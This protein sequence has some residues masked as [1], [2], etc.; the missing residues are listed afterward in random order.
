MYLLI[1]VNTYFTRY[2]IR[3]ILKMDNNTPHWHLLVNHHLDDFDAIHDLIHGWDLDFHQLKPGNSPV[4]ICQFGNPEFVITK[5]DVRQAYDQRGAAADNAI[6]LAVLEDGIEEVLCPRG[7]FD[8]SGMMYFPPGSDINAVSRSR[9]KGYTLT[10]SQALIDEVCYQQGLANPFDNN[11]REQKPVHCGLNRMAV[12]RQGLRAVGRS[13]LSR[14]QG[15]EQ[16]SW[17]QQV[18]LELVTQLVSAISRSDESTSLKLSERKKLTLER[19]L[20]YIESYQNKDIS[21][22]ELA[23]ACGSSVRTLEYVF[24]D[25]FGVTPKA[26]LKAQR[27][28]ATRKALL[29]AG[30]GQTVNSIAGLYGFWHM[31]QFAAD[32]KRFFG[33]LP[34]ETMNLA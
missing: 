27:L 6:T 18:E 15:Y 12:L 7:I 32:Y 23:T 29:N 13:F 9:F 26:Y 22:L 5:F 16:N 8:Q 14:R 34:S 10:I 30:D 21:V 28:H 4:D 17:I 19:A 2:Q 1:M 11:F 25:Y 3:I 20:A 31:G 24:K 33:E